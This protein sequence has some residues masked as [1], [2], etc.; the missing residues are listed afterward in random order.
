[1]PDA[2]PT[3][4]PSAFRRL[5]PSRY[6]ERHGLDFEDFNAG[7]RF[8]HRP[9]V[10]V[11]QQDNADHALD[12]FNSAMLH[13]DAA[14]AEQTAWGRPLVVSTLT[15]ERVIG[16]CSK[17]FGRRRAL[18]GFDDIAL[19]SPVFGGDTLYAES[20]I[21]DTADGDDPDYGVVTVRTV[22]LTQA[23]AIAAE[24]VYR[25]AIYR[26]GRG[27][28][29]DPAGPA[30]N[31]PRFAA[32]A[33][34]DGALVER[35]GLF[36]EDCRPGETFVHAPRRTFLRDEAIEHARRSLELSPQY[37]DLE[38]VAEHGDGRLRIPETLVLA[39]ATTPSTRTF[40]RVVANLGW[41]DIEFPR[42]VFAGDTVHCESEILEA[43]ESR[44]RAG[45]GVLAV[46]TRAFDQ[47]GAVVLSYR[48]TLLVHRAANLAAYE[49]S[50]YA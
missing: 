40:G 4:L 45:E 13:F 41:R 42:P 6:A 17:T 12:T 1:M 19:R 39:A 47:T 14:Y 30:A 9:G 32:Y 18:L 34:V 7:Q 23:A 27:P 43:R 37:H 10:T 26:R 11:S 35:F 36:F 3:I 38:W 5:G 44:S 20:E 15:V 29:G 31:E 46:A 21:L 25:T 49:R 50:G 28:D 16:M 48:R 22:G 8:R 2:S 33:E 24:L